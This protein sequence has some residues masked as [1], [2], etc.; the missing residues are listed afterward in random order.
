M[1]K[2]LLSIHHCHAAT[3]GAKTRHTTM[4]ARGGGGGGTIRPVAATNTPSNH[5]T[6][7]RRPRFSSE[8]HALTTTE[9]AFTAEAT[10][11]NVAKRNRPMGTEQCHKRLDW[12]ALGH[13][14]WLSG[15][16][17]RSAVIKLLAP[18][19]TFERRNSVNE[20]LRA[21]TYCSVAVPTYFP[22]ENDVSNERY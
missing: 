2:H 3:G 20:R 12:G 8:T 18:I 15:A 14:P 16:A 7:T 9:R 13:N 4:R 21:M 11:K 1:L 17:F 22:R 6:I 5:F 19:F 10:Q